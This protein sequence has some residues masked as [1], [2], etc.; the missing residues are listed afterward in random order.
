MNAAL[1]WW[2]R[3]SLPNLPTETPSQREKARYARL[4]SGFLL[5]ISLLFLP[6]AFI[7]IFDSPK[8][9]SSPPIAMI[10][11]LILC[12]AFI[13]GRMGLNILS[14]SCIVFYDIFMVTGVLLSNP[15]DP[16]LLPLFGA[17]VLAT[18]IASALM[19]RLH[20]LLSELFA[21]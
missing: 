14:A 5:L 9:P 1:S 17:F 19:P 6:T 21:V 3:L 11:V 20:L 15:L 13:F 16:S 12:G 4:T 10:V 8:S 2:F 18:I 7:M